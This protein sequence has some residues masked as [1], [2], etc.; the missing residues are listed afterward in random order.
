VGLAG[1]GLAGVTGGRLASGGR[2][3]T[4]LLSVACALAGLAFGLLMDFSTWLT[5]A[6]G[7]SSGQLDIILGRGIPFNLAHAFGNVVFCLA[8]GPILLRALTRFRLRLEPHW[9]PV[10]AAAPLAALAVAAAAIA[11]PAAAHAARPDRHAIKRA[12]GYLRAAQNTDGGFGAARG[13][14]SGQLFTAWAS[15]G[16]ACAGQSPAKAGR[17]GRSA[18]DFVRA[19]LG[20]VHRTAD[21]E[22][23]ILAVRAGRQVAG[24]FGGRDLVAELRARRRSD[25]SFGGLVNVTSFAV[26]ALR[27]AGERRLAPEVRAAGNWLIRQRNRN[28][29]FSFFRRG[30]ASGIDDTAGAVQA[31]VAAGRGRTSTVKRALAYLRRQ[32]NRS[33]GFPLTPGQG[34]N[35]QSTSWAIQAVVAAGGNPDRLR[36]R[37]GHTARSYLR[38]LMGRTGAVRYSR[39]SAQTPVWVTAQAVCAFALRPLPVH[40]R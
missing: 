9:L 21:I 17:S 35:A 39:T 30:A 1:A 27:A 22:R 14:A 8:F 20:D 25:G 7:R 13:S 6:E 10:R 4:V 2:R 36:R 24:S 31:L 11:H 23:T 38:G 26:L 40:V 5:Y 3:A 15:M 19:G 16:L 33:G 32:Q 12:L 18:L 34:S 37:G 29:G 28:G